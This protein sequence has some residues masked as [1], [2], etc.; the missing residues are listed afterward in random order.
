VA[1][2]LNTFCTANT[3][4]LGPTPG[5]SGGGLGVLLLGLMLGGVVLT[6]KRRDPRWALSF[7]V[8]TLIALGGAACA[9][10]PK[11]PTGTATPPGK[12]SVTFSATVNGTTTTTPPI[13]FT[14][15]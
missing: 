10:L 2:V 4:P 7:A 1:I 14:V 8:L 12:Y 11:S 3:A 9:S 6:I 13:N 15:E 5:G